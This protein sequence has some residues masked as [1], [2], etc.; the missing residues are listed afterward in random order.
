MDAPEAIWQS[1]LLLTQLVLYLLSTMN[2][3]KNTEGKWVL[4]WI[5]IKL[6]AS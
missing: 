3:F 2:V 5:L 1:D 4:T 6:Y